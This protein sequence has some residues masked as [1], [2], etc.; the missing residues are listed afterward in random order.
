MPSMQYTSYVFTLIAAFGVVITGTTFG[1]ERPVPKSI[2]TLLT[3]HC[4]DCHQ[5]EDAQQGIDLN[6]SSTQLTNLEHSETLDRIYSAVKRRK[7]PPIDAAPLSEANRQALL[8]WLLQELTMRSEDAQPTQP[9]ARRLTNFEYQNTIRDLVGFEVYLIDDLPK[10]PVAPYR[11]N[12]TAEFMRMGPEQFNR[13]LEAARKVMASAI[14]NPEPPEIH[15]T[16]V[17]WQPHGTDRGLGA[18]EVGVWGNRRNTPATGMGLRSF[19]PRG[20]FLIRIQA[21]AI[22]PQGVKEIPLRLVLGYNL[23]ENSSTLRIRPVGTISLSNTPDAPQVFEFRGRIE[24]FPTQPGRVVNDKRQPD[25]LTITFQNLYD[26]GTL[27]DDQAFLSP[28]N[29]AMPRA[30]INWA[31]FE[32]PSIRLMA[33]KSPYSYPVRISTA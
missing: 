1:A 8:S 26:D 11:F 29:I 31:E 21:S 13:Y 23:N 30:V 12:N 6:R 32:G 4:A 14:V 16:R 33:T 28:R 18:D 9:V 24:N 19:P 20:E 22:L 2:Q 15:K 17:E 27:N 10:D 7:M 25:R 5:G 3:I